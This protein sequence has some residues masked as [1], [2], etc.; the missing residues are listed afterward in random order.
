V[1]ISSWF[2]LAQGTS[3]HDLH[4]QCL[5]FAG[6]PVNQEAGTGQEQGSN[7]SKQA[8]QNSDF[9]KRKLEKSLQQTQSI[10][11]AFGQAHGAALA[12]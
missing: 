3:H 1:L 4:A 6:R 10:G 5:L 12:G 8:K 2:Q 9:D 7:Q 11:V